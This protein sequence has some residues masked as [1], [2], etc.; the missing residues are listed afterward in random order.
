MAMT[1][2]IWVDYRDIHVPD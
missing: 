2:N 1:C